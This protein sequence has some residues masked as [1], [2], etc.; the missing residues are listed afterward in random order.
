M[1]QPAAVAA[2]LGRRLCEPGSLR[3]RNFQCSNGFR[4]LCGHLASDG[5]KGILWPHKITPATECRL[6]GERSKAWT[7]PRCG[8]CSRSS[9]SPPSVLLPLTGPSSATG[10]GASPLRGCTSSILASPARP[11]TKQFG[12]IVHSAIIENGADFIWRGSFPDLMV[13]RGRR[14]GFMQA[15]T[16]R[17]PRQ[18]LS[19]LG[20]WRC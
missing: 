16:L 10:S 6:G 11:H 9:S 20:R 1:S 2:S 19:A 13:A 12:Q 14:G 5:H 3:I 18:D 17:A 7:L 8:P 15:V 4:E